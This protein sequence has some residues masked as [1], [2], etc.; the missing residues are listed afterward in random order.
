MKHTSTYNILL[1]LGEILVGPDGENI[2]IF[3]GFIFTSAEDFQKANVMDHKIPNRDEGEA[4]EEAEGASE[5]GHL[6]LF[7]KG[8]MNRKSA[9]CLFAF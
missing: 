6:K 3:S 2:Q 8:T 7:A 5:V 1:F 9:S 4:N